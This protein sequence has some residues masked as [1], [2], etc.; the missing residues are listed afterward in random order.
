[1][2]FEL[3]FE[4]REKLATHGHGILMMTSDRVG[5]VRLPSDGFTL[6]E[7]L[8][9][10]AVLGILTA[11]LIPAIQ[12]AREAARRIECASRL[13]QLVIAATAHAEAKGHFPPGVEQWYFNEAVS[14]RGI[15]LFA[16]LL[17]YLEQ[18]NA[19]VAWDYDNPI[20]NSNQGAR[21]NTAVVIPVFLCPS[22]LIPRNPIVMTSRDWHYALA[23]YGGNG[24]TRSYFPLQAT[25]DGIFHTT[26]EASE[27][28]NY[29]EPVRPKDV[30]DGLSHTLLLGERSHQD[31]NYLSFNQAGWGEPLN[32][33]GWWGA[34]NSRKMIGHVT[35]STHAP[36]NYRLPFSYANR[37]GKN[38]SADSFS[39]F[40]TY[41]DL[42]L[43]AYGSGHPGGVNFAFGDGSVR[44]TSDQIEMSLLRALSTRAGGELD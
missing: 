31:P 3:V 21:S 18:Q 19:L 2:G 40:Q 17:P 23:S 42:R 15:P 36:I 1:L 37:V 39:Q 4:R 13:K 14:H 25:A 29:Q 38:P 32:E 24:G 30:A 16:F 12:F 5:R 7:L 6:I 22:D 8:V 11:I 9:V 28:K 41:V 20:N 27:P 35:M 43:C 34:S 44:F 33:Q 10:I 26:G